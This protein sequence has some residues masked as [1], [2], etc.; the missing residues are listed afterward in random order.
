MSENLAS[1]IMIVIIFCASAFIVGTMKSCSIEGACIR[2]DKPIE[3]LKELRGE[4][5]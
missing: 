4:S 3:C 2:S 5:S 1:L